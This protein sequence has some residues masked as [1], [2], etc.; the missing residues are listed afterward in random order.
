MSSVVQCRLNRAGEYY[1][2]TDDECD[3]GSF[4][5]LCL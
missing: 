1:T 3:Y 4:H 2:D 5:V